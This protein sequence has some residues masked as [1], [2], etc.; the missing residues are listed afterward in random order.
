MLA[1]WGEHDAV[2]P[3][4]KAAEVARGVR[5]GRVLRIDDAGHL[6]PAEQPTVTAR[7]LLDFFDG[8]NGT[9]QR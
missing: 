5:D 4:S 2:A 9:E 1:V 8:L 7:V 6:P 3:E